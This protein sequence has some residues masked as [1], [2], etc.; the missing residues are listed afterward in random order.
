[1]ECLP[2]RLLWHVFALVEKKKIKKISRAK[3]KTMYI[4]EYVWKSA[5]RDSKQPSIMSL[6]FAGG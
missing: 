4:L 6:L 2:G 1:M 5:R 3:N